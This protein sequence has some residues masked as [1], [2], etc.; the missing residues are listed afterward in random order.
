M[1]EISLDSLEEV[2]GGA[3]KKI[4]GT[5]ELTNIKHGVYVRAGM[6]P[7][8]PKIEF[9]HLGDHLPYYGFSGRW[10]KVRSSKGKIGYVKKSVVMVID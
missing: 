4:I 2:S 5:V 8:A 9:R 7:D 10:C 1:E 6:D 3:G